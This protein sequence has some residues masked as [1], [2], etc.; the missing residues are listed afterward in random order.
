MLNHVLLQMLSKRSLTV[1]VFVS[2]VHLIYGQLSDASRSYEPD[3]TQLDYV[4]HN[5]EEMTNY[6]R[7]V[8]DG[9]FNEIQFSCKCPRHNFRRQTAFRY[10]NLT[11]LY[12]IGKLT[13]KLNTEPSPLFKAI[14]IY[15]AQF[16]KTFLLIN[17]R[18]LRHSDRKIR[19]RPWLVGDGGEFNKC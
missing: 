1:I 4:Y 19:S 16:A 14:P 11:A 9:S 8:T 17:F 18:L 13:R 2:C 10:P 12:S 7:W 15:L 5:H 3:A 6:L